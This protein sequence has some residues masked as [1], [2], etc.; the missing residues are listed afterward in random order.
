MDKR[1]AKGRDAYETFR[2]HCNTEGRYFLPIY[3]PPWEMLS[4]MCQTAWVGYACGEKTTVVLLS[5]QPAVS[6]RKKSAAPREDKRPPSALG[7]GSA[8]SAS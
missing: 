8:R 4:E 7:Y 1:Q 5:A 6:I 3:H 2:E